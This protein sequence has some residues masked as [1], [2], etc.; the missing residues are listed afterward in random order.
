MTLRYTGLAVSLA[1]AYPPRLPLGRHPFRALS[2]ALSLVSRVWASSSHPTLPVRD[3]V[4]QPFLDALHRRNI[5][6]NLSI[7]A[8]HPYPQSRAITSLAFADDVVVAVAGLESLNLLDDL[9]L[10]W[11]HAMNGRLNT[12]KTVVLPIGRR[13]DPGERPIVVKAAGES[14]EWI[15]LPF[16]P[17]GD[18]ELAYAN[19]IERLEATLEVVQHRWLTHH[20][21]AFYVNRYTIPKILHFLAADIPPPEVVKKLDDMLV[22]FVRG[23]KGRTSYGRDIVFTAKNKGGLGVIRMRDVVDA[24]AARLWDVLLGGSGAIWQGLARAALQR[25][26][27]DL[28]LAT[29]LWP[30]PSTPIPDGTPHWVFRNFTTRRSTRGPL[31]GNVGGDDDDYTRETRERARERAKARRSERGVDRGGGSRPRGNR[32]GYAAARLAASPVYRTMV[33][34]EVGQKREGKRS[35]K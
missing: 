13:W 1:A 10:D 35:K 12:D 17:S 25:A 23:G 5:A 3:I 16:D 22:D 27:P 33:A 11:R 24:V 32:G 26:Q 29:D 2:L 18:T 28:D 14:L 9:A 20:T 7:P 34:N 31:T 15:G 30:H 21:H 4:F 6:L 19:L 8:L